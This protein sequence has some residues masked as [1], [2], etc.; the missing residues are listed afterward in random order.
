MT[1]LYGRA[2]RGARV[3]DHAPDVRFERTS[4][5]S[6]VRLDGG[7][8]PMVFRGA[9]DGRTFAA[10]VE[11]V[12]APTLREG[13]IV[14]MDNLSSHKVEGV[15]GPIYARGAEVRFLPPYSPDF[16]PIEEC[17]SKVKSILRG[18]KARTFDELVKAVGAALDAVTPSDVSGWFGHCGYGVNN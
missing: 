2:A 6:T 9:L 7:Q 14:V 17:W 18:L 13:D 8:A 5:V 1:R 4:I 16:N 12:L 15:L 11:D 3:R 10:Y